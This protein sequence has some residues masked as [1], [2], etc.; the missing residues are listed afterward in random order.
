MGRSCCSRCLMASFANPASFPLG[1]LDGPGTHA[2]ELPLLRWR[3][4]VVYIEFV[5]V[6]PADQTLL[7][8]SARNI[9]GFNA[10]A[11]AWHRESGLAGGLVCSPSSAA[12]L[13]G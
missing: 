11:A 12:H 13:R 7:F 10:A 9:L 3:A 1:V 5:R 2:S 6:C 8:A 4:S